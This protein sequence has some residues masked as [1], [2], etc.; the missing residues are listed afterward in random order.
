[1]GNTAIA[2]EFHEALGFEAFDQ[3]VVCTPGLAV[4]AHDRELAGAVGCGYLKD[5]RLINTKV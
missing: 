3:F 4:W 5:G 1:L 2:L